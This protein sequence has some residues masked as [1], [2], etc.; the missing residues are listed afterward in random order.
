M[1]LNVL[2]LVGVFALLAVFY[3][4]QLSTA[5]VQ[6]MPAG[7]NASKDV[8]P[9]PATAKQTQPVTAPQPPVVAGKTSPATSTTAPESK[10]AAPNDK[11]PVA[12]NKPPVPAANPPSSENK[13]VALDNKPQVAENKPPTS[14]GKPPVATATPPTPEVKPPAPVSKPPVP[15]T[16]PA[17]RPSPPPPKAIA[18]P[19]GAG[20]KVAQSIRT[21]KQIAQALQNYF[22][23]TKRYPTELGELTPKYLG[24]I[25]LDPCTSRSYYYIPVNTPPT[26]YILTTG[27]YPTGS[28]CRSVSPGLSYTTETGIQNSP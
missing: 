8:A 17:P 2:V 21:M 7:T 26:D 28:L 3:G 9:T 10:T 18:K 22:R 23:D 12:E 27:R 6:G 4:R 1:R 16:N 20:E 14:E 5:R 24:A 25:P 15:P 11:P 19:N 13:P